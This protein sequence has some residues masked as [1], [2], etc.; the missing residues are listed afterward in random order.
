MEFQKIV[1]FLD[2][3]FDNKDLPKFVTKKWIEVY[4]QSEKNYNPNKEI[5]IKTSMLRSGLCDYSDA[6]IIV[7][8]TITVTNPND[9]KRNK[10]VAFKNNAP[11][12][13]FISNINGV[14]IDNTEDLYVVMPMYNLLEYS[15]NYKK[16][17]GSLWNYY[18]DE[19]TN[20]RSSNSES[21]KYKTSITGNTYNIGDGKKGMMTMKLVKMKLKL[22]FH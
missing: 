22:L 7:K 15:K 9:A 2:T 1:N 21:V 16:T 18:R 6:Y 13:N 17:I 20:P 19:P 5:R 11:S 12:I 4:D 14:K 10:A 8:G 3:T